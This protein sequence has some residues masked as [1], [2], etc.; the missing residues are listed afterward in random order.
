MSIAHNLIV[1]D[2]YCLH[3]NVLSASECDYLIATLAKYKEPNGRAGIR[4]LMRVP[5]VQAL[6]SDSRLLQI[7]QQ[8]LGSNAIPFRA[9]LFAKS[10]RANWLVSWH[11]DTALPLQSHFR[12]DDW[13]GWSMKKGILYAHAP[14]WALQRIV[15]L[16]VHLDAATSDNGAL[17]VIP[18]SHRFG[19]LSDE[20]I[21]HFA[22]KQANDCLLSRGDVL[23]MR[24]LLLHA[25]SKAR[26]DMPR[27]VLHIE[28]VEDLKLT[29]EIYLAVV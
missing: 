18:G 15:A 14:A 19:I 4:H 29:P 26:L 8:A 11:Q 17:R 7:A 23:A 6:A 2:G 20:E 9:T 5:E 22:Q 1:D 27:R 3:E 16:R 10:G 28:Y 21:H 12:S 24:P 13:Q 25:S